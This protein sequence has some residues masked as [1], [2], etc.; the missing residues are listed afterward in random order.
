MISPMVH[1]EQEMVNISK[2]ATKIVQGCGERTQ[3]HSASVPGGV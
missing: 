2:I 3:G 1:V